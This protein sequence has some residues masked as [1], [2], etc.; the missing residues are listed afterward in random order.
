MTKVLLLTFLGCSLTSLFAAQVGCACETPFQIRSMLL[1]MSGT[2]QARHFNSAVD[3]TR[4]PLVGQPL[5]AV[6]PNRAQK[7]RCLLVRTLLFQGTRLQKR[8]HGALEPLPC[9]RRRST[10]TT[11]R[12]EVMLTPSLSL[13]VITQQTSLAIFRIPAAA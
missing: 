11:I 7:A 10:S 9:F 13:S 4:W 5:P 12:A 3:S 2:R 8:S 1:G 6:V